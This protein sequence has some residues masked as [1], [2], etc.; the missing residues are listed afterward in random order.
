MP[1]WVNVLP[2]GERM[3][4]HIILHGIAADATSHDGIY[5]AVQNFV[6]EY[7]YDDFDIIYQY[8]ICSAALLA[9]ILYVPCSGSC[10][11]AF[12][13]TMDF[14]FAGLILWPG[15]QKR[16]ALYGVPSRLNTE[17]NLHTTLCSH[18]QVFQH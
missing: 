12:E 4:E 8:I 5:A 18:R 14:T 16:Y 10:E 11:S 9:V 3:P 7:D 6:I 1:A 13:K 2:I 17:A 15:L